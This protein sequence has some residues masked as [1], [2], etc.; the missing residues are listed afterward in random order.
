MIFDERKIANGQEKS[1]KSPQ[2]KKNTLAH[3]NTNTYPWNIRRNQIFEGYGRVNT[4]VTI[5]FLSFTVAHRTNE[6]IQDQWANAN[7]GVIHVSWIDR[8]AYLFA[9]TLNTNHKM[10]FGVLNPS[11]KTKMQLQNKMRRKNKRR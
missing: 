10:T 11:E 6:A 8:T 5:A 1:F 4:M 7:F 9:K 3:T 2:M